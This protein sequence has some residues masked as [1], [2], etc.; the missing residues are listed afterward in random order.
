MYRMPGKT[1]DLG[2]PAPHSSHMRFA[3]PV[4]IGLHL[5]FGLVLV[6]D[7]ARFR[8][9]D[10]PGFASIATR[11]VAPPAEGLRRGNSTSITPEDSSEEPA[12]P[13]RRR[14]TVSAPGRHSVLAMLDRA[15][16]SPLDVFG[17]EEGIP[18]GTLTG[19]PDGLPE[20]VRGGLPGGVPGGRIG[21]P[22]GEGDPIL[23][24][25]DEP[26][27]ALLTPGPRFPEEAVRS[28]VRG[29]VVLRALITE[30]GSVEVLRVLR[31][32]P[33]L[34]REATRLVESEWRFR[35]AQRN[36]RPVA[37]LSDLVVRFT[38]R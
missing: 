14:T 3:I 27:V 1:G 34:D 29:R 21:A 9:A 38:L 22:R 2:A 31:S 28:G 5:G 35:P 25:P 26:P 30:R 19:F 23:P 37:A 20:G 7:A 24:P 16:L 6:H 13:E 12:L 33:E 8:P 32:V 17:F 18:Q 11:L 36:G 10:L 4:G 15:P